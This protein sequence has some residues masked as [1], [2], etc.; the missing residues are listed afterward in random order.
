MAPSSATRRAWRCCPASA[1]KAIIAQPIGRFA[2]G[3]AENA[4]EA[5]LVVRSC[6]LRRV[7]VET[8]GV[9]QSETPVAGMVDI[10]CLLQ[11][12]NAGDD[13][14]AIKKGI[15]EIADLV[16]SQQADID[17]SATAVVRA[18]M[19]WPRCTMLR[20]ASP[21]LAPPVITASALCT[22][23]ALPSFWA[24]IE[25]YREGADA[26]RRV[27]AK[28]QAARH[29]P[30]CGSLIDSG[31]APAFQAITRT[32]AGEPSRPNSVERRDDASYRGACPCSPT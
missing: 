30:G 11:L 28:A 18:Q 15:V 9:G 21:Q 25:R 16:L 3:V 12:P 29:W 20:P 8:V 10:F 1:T 17:P 24:E 32:R 31:T 2:G 23:K 5:M 4:R 13:L 19:A 6:R 22:R 7:I 14:Q 27:R 26:D